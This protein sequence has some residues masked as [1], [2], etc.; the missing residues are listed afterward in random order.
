MSVKKMILGVVMTNVYF[1]IND[2]TKE[3]VLFDPA[4]GADEILGFAERNSLKIKAICL[5]HGHFDHIMALNEVKKATQAKVYACAAEE[6]L[7]TDAGL[8]LSEE[9]TGRSCIVEGHIPLKDGDV[10][11]EAG[12]KIKLIHTPGHTE[13]SCCY[14]IEDEKILFSGDTLF[15]GSVGRTDL[16]TGSMRQITG[17]LKD[18]LLILPDDVTVYPGHGEETDI[19]YEKKYNPFVE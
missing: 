2:E 9:A 6:R 5:T 13:G 3:A 4:D 10:I 18:K 8:N 17:S 7:L 19:G 16:P 14:Y 12:K 11:D 15:C 1:Y